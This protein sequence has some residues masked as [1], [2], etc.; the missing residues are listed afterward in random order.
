MCFIFSKTSDWNISHSMNKSVRYNKFTRLHAKY[1]LFLSDF[2]ETE[3]SWQIFKKFSNITLHENPSSWNQVFPCEQTDLLKLIGTF[4]KK[5]KKKK[6]SATPSISLM[7]T[8]IM[9]KWKILGK[10]LYM[11]KW[12]GIYL[13]DEEN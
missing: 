8:T 7:I 11:Q 10:R 12:L 2:N 9:V 13:N 5:P 1:L 4:M 6:N 3:F